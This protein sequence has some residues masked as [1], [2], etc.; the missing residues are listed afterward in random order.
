M[1]KI[2]KRTISILVSIC[3]IVLT[4]FSAYSVTESQLQSE[5]DKLQKQSNA[6]QSEINALKKQQG[7]QAAVLEA[8]R[9]KIANTQAQINRCNAEI[10]GINEKIRANKAEIDAKNAEIEADKL[11]FQKR[12][13]AIYMSNSASTVKV[14]LGAENFSEFLQLSQLTSSVSSRDKTMMKDLAAA[15][16][17]L[18]KKN[19]ENQKL[20]DSQIAIRTTIIE[21][22]NELKNDENE[23]NRLYK[24]ISNSKQEAEGEKS[25]IDKTIKELNRQKQQLISS[26]GSVLTGSFV[27]PNT[28]LMWPSTCR[29]IHSGWGNRSGGFHYGIDISAAGIAGTPVFA[30][31]DGKVYQTFSGCTH[32]SNISDRCGSGFGNHVR[33]DH[34]LMNIKGQQQTVG[35]IYAHLSSVVVRDGQTVKQ[36]QIIGYVGSSGSSTGYHLHLTL[37]IGGKN[38]HANAVN[39]APY[40]YN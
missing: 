38:T 27:N 12:I 40:F 7:N 4:A 10:N 30:I 34:G 2:L 6:I 15:I 11:Q 24:E 26:F 16:E 17:V 39:P 28:G 19:E 13:R 9:K 3:I 31:A 25:D 20:L 36:G 22:Q 14:L 5:I 35:A 29:I 33:I 21:K 23:A 1:K 18:N 8:I 32:I 37:L